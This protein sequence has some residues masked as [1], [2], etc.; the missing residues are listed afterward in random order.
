MDIGV[1]GDDGQ[2]VISL[3]HYVSDALVHGS[4]HDNLGLNNDVINE[5]LCLM[6]EK[7]LITVSELNSVTGYHKGEEVSF[8]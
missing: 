1:Y 3:E 7:R 4:N 8:L 2:R 6:V 5:L